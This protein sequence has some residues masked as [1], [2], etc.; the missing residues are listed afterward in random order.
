MVSYRC[1]TICGRM[2]DPSAKRNAHKR[3]RRVWVREHGP[4]PP[5]HHIHHRD[6]NPLNNEIA[7]L[8][9]LPSEAHLSQDGSVA[10]PARLAARARGAARFRSPEGRAAARWFDRSPADKERQRQYAREQ[11]ARRALVERTCERCGGHF[12]TRLP[13][14]EQARFCSNAC[15]TAWRREAGLD[16]EERACEVCG[17]R[18][19]INRY[20]KTRTC[21][22]ACKGRLMGDQRRGRPRGSRLQSDGRRDA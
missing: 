12:A 8:E 15:K 18:F 4:I 2:L 11:M 19:T 14:P 16:N 5:G 3:A 6:K 17:A 13:K 10:T 7:N 20:A 9:C 1:G 21:S 22:P